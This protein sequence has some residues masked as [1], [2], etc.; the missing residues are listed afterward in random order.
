MIEI[1]QALKDKASKKREKKSP[2]QRYGEHIR[3]RNTSEAMKALDEGVD[4]SEFDK[5]YEKDLTSEDR[6]FESHI[7]NKYLRK[8]QDDYYKKNK[9]KFGNN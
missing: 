3:N 1:L 4:Q 8:S 9:G 6:K 5:I 7:S 2:A